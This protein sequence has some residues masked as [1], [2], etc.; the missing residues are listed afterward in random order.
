[1]NKTKREKK[2]FYWKL[3]A[4]YVDLHFY[5]VYFLV[6]SYCD[7]SA[8]IAYQGMGVQVCEVS[9]SPTNLLWTHFNEWSELSGSGL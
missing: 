8:P 1:M 2:G 7:S 4:L 9:V 3:C 5:K 6:S